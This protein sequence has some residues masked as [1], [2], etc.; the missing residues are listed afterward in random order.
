MAVIVDALYAV[1]SSSTAPVPLPVKF[2]L[3]FVSPP[4]ADIIGGLFVTLLAIL[5]SLTAVP[6]VVKSNTTTSSPAESA[7]AKPLDIFGRPVTVGAVSVLFVN[8][9]VADAVYVLI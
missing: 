9:A 8:V 4:V 3:T 7:S 6:A 2:K 5:T 1:L